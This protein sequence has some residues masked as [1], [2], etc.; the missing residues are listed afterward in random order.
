MI[1]L[2]QETCGVILRTMSR[3]AMLTNHAGMPHYSDTTFR[4][5]TPCVIPGN[6]YMMRSLSPVLPVP[7]TLCALRRIR[8]MIIGTTPLVP[9]FHASSTKYESIRGS[10]LYR[11][12]LPNHETTIVG[13]K[14]KELHLGFFLFQR[15]LT[16]FLSLITPSDSR[17]SSHSVFFFFRLYFLWILHDFQSSH[18]VLQQS[19]AEIMVAATLDRC[20]SS[21][22]PIQAT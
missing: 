5:F 7:S 16:L 11:S 12:H 17:G 14:P 18:W 15:T 4:T 19:V 8:I 3:W 10:I 2:P 1:T 21:I 22:S 13:L 6:S 20:Y 9:P